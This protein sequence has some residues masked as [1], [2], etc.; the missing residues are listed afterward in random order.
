[1]K[2]FLTGCLL[3]FAVLALWRPKLRIDTR[4]LRELR[5]QWA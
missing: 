5:R 4:P 3:T 2:P 1:M